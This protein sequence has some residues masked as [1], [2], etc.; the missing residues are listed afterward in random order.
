VSVSTIK[1]DG[2]LDHPLAENL[3]LEVDVFLSTARTYRDVV[4]SLYKRH[5][6]SPPPGV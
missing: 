2:L 1:E 6:L 5:N 3:C 4:D